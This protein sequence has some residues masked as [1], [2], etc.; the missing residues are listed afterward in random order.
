MLKKFPQ[1]IIAVPI[2]YMER[3]S[4]MNKNASYELKERSDTAVTVQV[5]VTPETVKNALDNTYRAYGREASIPGFR[6]GRVPR[7]VL[8]AR[9]GHELFLEETQKELQQQ[10]LGEALAELELNPVAP[11][12]I[13]SISFD[14]KEP[15]VFE[16]S[17]PVLPD[18]D[19]PEYKGIALEAEPIKDITNDDVKLALDDIRARFGTIV[20]KD[21]DTVTEGDIVQVREDDKEW[22]AHAEERNPVTGKLIG[23][24]VGETVSVNLDLPEKKTFSASLSI[25]SLQ[26]IKIPEANDELAKDAGYEN[27][28]ALQAKVKESLQHNQASKHEK[29]IKLE[30][31]DWV[32][33][34]ANIPLPEVLVEEMATE[35][36][37]HLKKNLSEPRSPLSFEDYLSKQDK[38]EEAI[39]ADYR[40]NVTRRLRRELVLQQIAKAQD[41]SFTDEKLE[42]IATAEAE[43]TD[44]NP[45]RFI[46]E[47][48]ANERWEDYRLAKVNMGVLDVLY[49]NAVLSEKTE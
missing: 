18:F 28:E 11:P 45:I 42:E 14:E 25:V 40:E 2:R 4:R 46:A 37:E 3:L 29:K 10:H 21:G 27:L 30:L 24:K 38:S 6:K 49:K 5:T 8:D 26:E 32:V 44:E 36:L 22:N 17:F 13:K 7:G 43:E 33:D 23:H 48:K 15:F 34:Q 39:Q 41:I 9:Y 12:E 1:R 47:L 20:P 35:E 16:A 31:L 19:L